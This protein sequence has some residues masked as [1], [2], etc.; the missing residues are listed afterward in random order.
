MS[1][2]TDPAV[3]PLYRPYVLSHGSHIILT[4][5]DTEIMNGNVLQQTPPQ[6]FSLTVCHSRYFKELNIKICRQANLTISVNL[7]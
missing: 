7:F 3:Q 5:Q 6:I 2:T 1:A 4:H